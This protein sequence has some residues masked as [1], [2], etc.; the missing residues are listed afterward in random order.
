MN[1]NF[2]RQFLMLDFA[3]LDDAQFIAFMNTAEFGTYLILRRYIWRGGALKPHFMGLHTLY[4]QERLLVSALS[5]EKL[6]AKL[7]LK[8]LTRISKQLTKLEE[9]GVVRRIRTG[10][11]SIY[12]L[13]E[14]LDYSEEQNSAKRLEWFYLDQ[15]FGLKQTEEK[16]ATTQSVD[17]AQKATSDVAQSARQT[18]RA[19]PHQTWRKTPHAMHNNREGNNKTV[20]G[21][22]SIFKKLPVLQQSKDKTEYVAKYIMEELRDIHSE[23]FYTLIAARIPEDVIRQGLAEIKADGAAEP[24]K[25]FTYKMHKYAIEKLKKKLIESGG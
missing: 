25:L 13:G 8:D 3:L 5:R 10:R 20:N 14:W 4:E 21:D 2:N 17:V 19:T 11:E 15:K 9:V 7:G 22:A 1:S 24:P 6:A 23:R 18:W 12:V 16:A